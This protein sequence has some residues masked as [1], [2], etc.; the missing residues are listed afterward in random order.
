VQD[1]VPPR[2]EPYR[3]PRRELNVLAWT[4]GAQAAVDVAVAAV[5]GGLIAPGRGGF[6]APGAAER[7]VEISGWLQLLG[8]VAGVAAG[9]AFA[10][11]VRRVILGSRLLRAPT[12]RRNPWA[13]AWMLV[14]VACLWM[15]FPLAADMW[16]ATHAGT[17]PVGDPRLDSRPRAPPLVTAWWATVVGAALWRCSGPAPMFLGL[18]YTPL[19]V[20]VPAAIGVTSLLLQ[21]RVA[22]AITRAQ[23]AQHARDGLSRDDAPPRPAA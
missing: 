5:F 22:S 12:V 13:G 3:S 23:E 15:P 7:L 2:A 10:L 6:V 14:P 16:R 18:A 19:L 4:L 1:D 20:L 11:W 17:R 9:V 21:H 8:F